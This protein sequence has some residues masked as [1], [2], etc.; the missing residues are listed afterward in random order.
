MGMPEKLKAN[1][2]KIQETNLG[3]RVLSYN[4]PIGAYISAVLIVISF[5][6]GLL[7]PIQRRS[8]YAI[9]A[10]LL[11]F[12]AALFFMF[13]TSFSL[14]KSKPA[15][16]RKMRRMSPIGQ[17]VVAI[18]MVLFGG[19]PVVGTVFLILAMHASDSQEAGIGFGL[20]LLVLLF[21][22]VP[23]FLISVWMMRVLMRNTRLPHQN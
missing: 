15:E 6:V 20:L 1:A 8:V 2:R 3:I 18:L 5:I 13:G 14:I 21:L 23:M 9:A 4:R 16:V 10:I 19:V 12:L 22:F 11:F 17:T 7:A